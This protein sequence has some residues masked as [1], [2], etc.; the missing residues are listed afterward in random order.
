MD[1]IERVLIHNRNRELEMDVLCLM[2][3]RSC[4][5]IPLGFIEKG[6]VVMCPIEVIVEM[7]GVE[8]DCDVKRV[9]FVSA[10]DI[11]KMRFILQIRESHQLARLIL[12]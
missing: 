1:G 8:K 3:T 9:V 11:E 10:I 7:I 6:V 12:A 2:I 4:V 5:F